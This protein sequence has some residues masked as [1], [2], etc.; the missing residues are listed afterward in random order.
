MTRC[1]IAFQ[2]GGW[3]GRV[4]TPTISSHSS[5]NGAK[6]T[7]SFHGYMDSRDESTMPLWRTL[8]RRTTLA[9]LLLGFMLIFLFGDRI[10]QLL[11]LSSHSV[12]HGHASPTGSGWQLFCHLG[13]NGPWIEKETEHGSVDDTL[14]QGCVVDQVNMMSRHGERFPTRNAGKRHFELLDKLEAPDVELSG[15]LEFLGKWT[16]FTSPEDPAFENLTSSGPYAGTEQAE[17]TGR[18][19]RERYHHL[20]PADREVR[21]WTCSSGRDVETA[22]FFADGFFGPGWDIDGVARLVVI[23]EEA[24]RGGDTLTP[25]DTCQRYVD[26]LEEGHDKGY[27]K[28]EQWQRL[29]TAPIVKRLQDA[30]R[31]AMLTHLD[32]Y[33][34]MEMC[35][36]EILA[37]GSSP[38]CNVFSHEEWRQFEYARDL[39]HFYRAGP[40]NKFSRTMGWLYLNATAELLINPS[41]SSVYFSFVH[42]GDIVPLLAALR[43]L[44]EDGPQYL[45]PDQL[46][47][48]RSW[49]TSDVVPMGGR[50]VFE[51]VACDTPERET[52][53]FVRLSINDG[54]MQIPGLAASVKVP[55]AV[56]VTDFWKFV[57]AKLS[58]YG[59]FAEICGLPEGAAT[60]ISFL[61]Q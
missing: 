53:R 5:M 51:R 26:D 18:R 9:Y 44:D 59:E 16:Y 45:P 22:R 36:F 20:V 43:L 58:E 35:G 46:I 29:F 52:E 39:L 37:R 31:G 38:W 57:D 27:G 41:A 6:A 13:G 7:A 25:G 19:F 3:W 48:N 15:S 21:F 30:A 49:R 60:R 32:V 42:D 54:V 33:S 56:A 1:P 40:G 24:D 17:N 10:A 50:V 8:R 11:L 47:S 61:H 14:P 34:M 23:P 55:S 2:L 28:L 12:T 4:E